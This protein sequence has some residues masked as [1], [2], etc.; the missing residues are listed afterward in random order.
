MRQFGV[1]A[2]IVALFMYAGFAIQGGVPA[3]TGSQGAQA[4]TSI[5]P[6]QH[7]LEATGATTD[8]AVITGWVEV[9]RPQARDRVAAAL[10]WNDGK[11]PVGETRDANLRTQDGRYIVTV[12]WTLTGLAA[13]S[14][15][16][17]LRA[18]RAA[19]SLAG[20]DPRMTVQLGGTTSG[21]DLPDVAGKALDAVAATGRQP[22][23]DMRAASVAG[24]TA[25]LPASSFGINIQVAVRHDALT[26]QD[27]VWVAWPA[28]LQ[29]Y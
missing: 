16:E 25:Q 17:K 29:E 4:A 23:S 28:L 5:M 27:K 26:N 15:N 14:W 11:A 6:L 19:L 24:I 22:W 20:A 1:I 8:T 2:S 3:M 21:E 13:R 10:N 18:A 9:D 12:R 7:A